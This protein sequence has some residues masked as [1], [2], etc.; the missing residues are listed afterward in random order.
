MQ[1]D[2]NARKLDERIRRLEVLQ[3]TAKPDRSWPDPNQHPEPLA[4][5]ETACP[6]VDGAFQLIL[7]SD[8]FLG[9]FHSRPP[10]R[11]DRLV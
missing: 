4:W 9:D 7:H 10:D 6:A 11:T 2:L 1:I 8:E 5:N 3:G